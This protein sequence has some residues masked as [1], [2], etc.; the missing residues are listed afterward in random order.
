M[1]VDWLVRNYKKISDR[2]SWSEESMTR[3][4]PLVENGEAGLRKAAKACDVT[5]S[6]WERKIKNQKVLQKISIEQIIQKPSM[7]WKI[8]QVLYNKM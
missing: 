8:Y 4:I 5:K 6:T 2:Q 7:C 1:N 3:V